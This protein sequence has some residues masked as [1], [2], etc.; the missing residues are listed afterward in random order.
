MGPLAILAAAGGVLGAYG[1]LQEGQ[2][3]ET[4]GKYNAKVARRNAYLVRQQAEAEAKQVI[5]TGRKVSGEMRAQYGAS[6]VKMEGSPMDVL[7]ESARL[8]EQDALNVR[9]QGELQAKAYEDE[10]NMELYK[11][12]IAKKASYLN[13]ASSLLTGGSQAY[14]LSR[15]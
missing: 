5:F 11:G 7:E 10:A 4:A 12:S 8:A 1:S 9:Y 15:A 6:G 13:A 3:A 14:K 2:A